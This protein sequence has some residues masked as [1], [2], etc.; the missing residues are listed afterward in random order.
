MYLAA[1]KENLDTLYAKSEEIIKKYN[2]QKSH[3]L[4][5]IASSVVWSYFQDRFA[6]TRYEILTGGNGGGKSALADTYGAIGYRPVNTTNPTAAVI[7][8]LL[9]SIEPGQCTMILEEAEKIDQVYEIMAILKT[10]YTRDGKVDRTNPVTLKPEFFNSYCYKIIVAE[11]SPSQDSGKGV[12]DRS[13]V[14]SCFKGY[15]E[16]DIKEVLNPTN[17]G[18][19]EH[20]ALRKELETFRKLLLM[21]QTLHFNDPI[22]DLDIGIT[23]RD[24][25]LVKPTLQLFQNT[26]TLPKLAEN[27]QIILDLKNGRKRTALYSALLNIASNLITKKVNERQQNGPFLDGKVEAYASEYWDILPVVILGQQDDKK[28]GEY[29]STEFG[30]LYK[31]TIGKILHDSFGVESEHTNKGALYTFDRHDINVS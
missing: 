1:K 26:E 13:F 24:K 20:Q 17:T 11:R 16:H 7:Y 4:V 19:P 18:G 25:E 14:H 5:S 31:G 10:G 21:Y 30:T 3:K 6:T 29:H 8:R 2:E 22:P 15:P 28:P 9:G 23:G 27:F 12:I